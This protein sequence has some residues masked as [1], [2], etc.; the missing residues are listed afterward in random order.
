MFKK[1]LLLFFLVQ[2]ALSVSQNSKK[3][4]SI[5]N[6]IQSSEVDSIK[7]RN[8]LAIARVLMYKDSKKTKNSIDH[9]DSLYRDSP[10]LKGLANLYGLKGEYLYSQAAYDSS[11]FYIEKSGNQY[12]KCND[13]VK[14]ATI[15]S[16]LVNIIKIISPDY[17][18]MEVLVNEIETIAIKYKDTSLIAIALEDRADIA[19]Y[20][21][22]RNIAI[23]LNKQVINLREAINDSAKL[24]QT[25]FAIGRIYQ[26]LFDYENSI[27]NFDEGIAIED[28]LGDNRLKSQLLKIKATS[29]IKLKQF[30]EAEKSL[31]EALK[32]SRAIKFKSNIIGSLIILGSL[33]E[34]RENYTKAS[35][36]LEEAHALMKPVNKYGVD[37]NYNLIR[38]R[39]CMGTKQ[40]K[41]ALNY[42]GNCVAIAE[43]NKIL[44]DLSVSK[45]YYSEALEMLGEH[46]KALEFLKKSSDAKDTITSQLRTTQ[47]IEQKIIFET[48]KK[49][50]QIVL[51]ESEIIVLEKNAKISNLQKLLLGVGLFLSLIAIGFGFYGF[52]QKINR[53]KAEKAKLDNELEFKKKE[54][55]THA[56][57]LAKKNEVLESLKSKAEILKTEDSN[58]KGYQQ[59]IKAINFDLQDDKNWDNFSR[60]FE[61]VHQGFSRKAKQEF[62]DITANDLRLMALLK[63]NLTSREI[64][65]ILSISS[66]GIK[67]A[68]YRLRKKL[69][70]ST[71]DSLEDFIL[72]FA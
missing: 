40:Y 63:M 19:L 9:A 30:N 48:E 16:N 33:E 56:L 41:S 39:V 6:L 14:A 10:N 46:K 65:N 34:E 4:D 32:I 62:P 53:N 31:L 21:G 60:Y 47:A 2:T 37:Y 55:T 42:F 61:E 7:A 28:A 54:L 26:E 70:L 29:Q 17:E 5:D 50:Q 23:K 11:L 22:H 25:Y 12:L 51:Q 1:Y 64:A 8:H 44:V 57:H 43:K 20:K 58:N 15:K 24:P 36:Y 27:V 13:S 68:R 38:G 69:Y 52:K 66:E 45:K 59:L 3:I 49:E 67:K 72:A 35:S 18:K 71:E